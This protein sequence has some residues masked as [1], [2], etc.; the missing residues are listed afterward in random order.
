MEAE[1]MSVRERL[2]G[3]SCGQCLFFSR[4]DED[5]EAGIYERVGGEFEQEAGGFCRRFPPMIGDGGAAMPGV[6]E[7]HWCGEWVAAF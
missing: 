4:Q 3:A 5:D 2:K 1:T 6:L 7:D